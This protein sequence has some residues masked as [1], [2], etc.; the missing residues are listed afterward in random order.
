[1]IPI[2]LFA[3]VVSIALLCLFPPVGIMIALPLAVLAVIAIVQGPK[4]NE[5]V[6]E[7]DDE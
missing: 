1:M 2:V 5:P 3:I 7:D 6:E 4:I